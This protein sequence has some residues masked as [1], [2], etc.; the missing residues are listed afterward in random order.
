MI[1]DRARKKFEIEPERG[2]SKI[3]LYS[4]DDRYNFANSL[5]YVYCDSIENEPIQA[6]D[7]EL[8]TTEQKKY[9]A[10]SIDIDPHC[11]QMVILIKSRTEEYLDT[12]TYSLE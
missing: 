7:P 10:I 3:V 6:I 5:I 4:P 9:N 8:E 11:D 12:L 2:K 1:I